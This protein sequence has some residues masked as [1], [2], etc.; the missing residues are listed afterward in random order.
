M[1]ISF[2]AFDM[3]LWKAHIDYVWIKAIQ[4]SPGA[5]RIS[6]S[7]SHHVEHSEECLMLAVH[8]VGVQHLFILN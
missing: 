2:I 3:P 5:T 1:R 8:I 4:S 7:N 6:C